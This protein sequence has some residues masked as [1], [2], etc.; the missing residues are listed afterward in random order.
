[1]KISL[2]ATIYG[3]EKF[4]RRFLISVFNQTISSDIEYIF[5][6]DASPDNSKSILNDILKDYPTLCVKLIENTK[7]EGPA[8]SRQKGY[9]NATG[10]YLL[11]LDS[12][13][14]IDENYAEKLL[15]NAEKS[16]SDIVF[17]NFKYEYINKTI[18]I[19]PNIHNGN[20]EKILYS[21]L[22]GNIHGS[23]CNKLVLRS[24]FTD[25]P[26]VHLKS[27]CDMMEDL[28][29]VYQLVY[30]SHKIS[31]EPSVAY[32]Y[33]L[34]NNSSIVHSISEAKIASVVK[35]DKLLSEFNRIH[36]LFQD[37]IGKSLLHL[38]LL[39]MADLS[40]LSTNI[41]WDNEKQVKHI[42]FKHPYLAF[43]DKLSLYAR[44][45][46]LKILHT[47]LKKL[48]LTHKKIRMS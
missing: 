23:W 46:N 43:T 41:N 2:I 47:L 17:T 42:I 14:W 31:Y 11:C 18:D 33:N 8:Y 15:Y 22:A 6:N 16:G 40:D 34:Q 20:K 39:S 21:L 13:D 26:I 45:C 12:D 29:I 25:N 7:N 4:I 44:L 9:Q 27:R 24:L 48:R 3:A 10:K 5:V 19:T 35:I 38:R 1:M 36:H 30:Y 28:Y 32:H 37:E